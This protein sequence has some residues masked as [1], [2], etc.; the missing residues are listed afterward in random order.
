[1]AAVP[2]FNFIALKVRLNQGCLPL[3][4][5]F[6]NLGGIIIRTEGVAGIIYTPREKY[7]QTW[8][9]YWNHPPSLAVQVTRRG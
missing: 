6:I 7:K 1:M 2:L 3:G 8:K 4:H 5:P 9:E